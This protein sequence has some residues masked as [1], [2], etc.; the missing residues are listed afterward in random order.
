MSKYYAF[1]LIYKDSANL[2]DH[3]YFM[4]DGWTYFGRKEPQISTASF[5]STST[6]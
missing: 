6:Y 1:R 2:L 3:C 4:V 5:Y